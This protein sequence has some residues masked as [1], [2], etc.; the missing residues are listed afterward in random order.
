MAESE[1]LRKGRE[2]R[3]LIREALLTAKDAFAEA[4]AERR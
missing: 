1:A 2:L 4:R 3:P